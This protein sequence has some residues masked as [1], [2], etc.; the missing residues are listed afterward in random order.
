MGVEAS[1]LI[2]RPELQRL[3]KS[4]VHPQEERLPLSH[5]PQRLSGRC[6][7]IGTSG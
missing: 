2:L 6:K 7:M 4:W 5:A 3:V 1:E